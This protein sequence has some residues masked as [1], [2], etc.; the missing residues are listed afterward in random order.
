MVPDG[1][2]RDCP[3]PQWGGGTYEDV[4]VLAEARRVALL[5]CNKEKAAAR[6]YQGEARKVSG[7][8]TDK[9]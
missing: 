1:L 7:E 8:K 3:I 2:L 6:L 4:A 9:N 5:D